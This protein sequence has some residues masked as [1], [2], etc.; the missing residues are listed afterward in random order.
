MKKKISVSLTVR[1]SQLILKLHPLSQVRLGGLNLAT[2]GTSSKISHKNSGNE[3]S[4]KESQVKSTTHVLQKYTDNSTDAS[5][6][7]V[8][9][10]DSKTT[11]G[12][13]HTADKEQQKNK[14]EK[15]GNHTDFSHVLK[16]CLFHWGNSSF[17]DGSEHRADF[18]EAH[19]EMQCEFML[20]QD[21]MRG[22]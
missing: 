13:K 12:P 4:A 19:M 11:P 16:Q 17:E 2:T 14:I 3:T 15:E 9:Q 5:T 10:V 20:P 8:G 21:M 22:K 6:R 1:E 7:K 18:R